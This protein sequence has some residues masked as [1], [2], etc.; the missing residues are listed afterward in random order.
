MLHDQNPENYRC[1]E[2]LIENL[3]LRVF[4]PKTWGN[5]AKRC[6]KDKERQTEQ[7][8]LERPHCSYFLAVS[9]ALNRQKGRGSFFTAAFAIK[10]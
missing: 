4:L 3:P 10:V 9:V 5:S 8:L 2:G 1:G 7:N 6:W